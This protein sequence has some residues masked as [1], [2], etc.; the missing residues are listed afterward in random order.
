MRCVMC[1]RSFPHGTDWPFPFCKEHTV[2]QYEAWLSCSK[3]TT[4][5]S[6]RDIVMLCEDIVRQIRASKREY[7]G[8]YGIPRGGIP[9]ADILSELLRL[10]EV[11]FWGVPKAWYKRSLVKCL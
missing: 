10:P 3:E 11:S 6:W 7:V 5:L 9:V 1:N 2:A 8:V 4:T